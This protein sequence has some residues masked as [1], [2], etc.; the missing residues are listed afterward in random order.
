MEVSEVEFPESTHTVNFSDDVENILTNDI[1]SRL[2]PPLL[3][4]SINDVKISSIK[5]VCNMCAQKRSYLLS[6]Q[7]NSTEEVLTYIFQSQHTP[8]IVIICNYNTC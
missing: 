3:D 1:F 6:N 4:T 2:V 5:T 7:S 8:I